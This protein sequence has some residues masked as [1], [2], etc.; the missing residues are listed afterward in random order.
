[1]VSFRDLV[2]AFRS[3]ELDN[4]P[5]IAHASLSAFGDVRGGVET[6]LGAL[7]S[8]SP[9]L[10]MPAFTYSTMVVP[11]TGPECNGITYGSGAYQNRTAEFFR[12]KLPVDPAIGVLAEELRRHANAERSLHPIFS[13]C[14]VNVPAALAAQTLQQPLAPIGA[15]ARQDGWVLLLGVDQTSNTSIHYA[16]KQAGRKQFLRWALTSDGVKECPNTPGC[17]QGFNA[18]EPYLSAICNRAHVG[19]TE[20]RALPLKPMIQIIRDLLAADPAAFLCSDPACER[21]HAVR[22]SLQ[23]Q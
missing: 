4:R 20:I 21:C 16:E 19:G 22:A 10:M 2:S 1:M 17:S 8:V 3:L 12:K 9:A 18:L 13:F 11:E 23:A 7:L 6:L 14:G 5:V 15:L